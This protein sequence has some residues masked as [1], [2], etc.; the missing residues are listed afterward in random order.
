M[1]T[2]VTNCLCLAAINFAALWLGEAWL[3]WSSTRHPAGA[4][5]PLHLAVSFA[6][7]LVWDRFS[8]TFLRMPGLAIHREKTLPAAALTAVFGVVYYA[9]AVALGTRLSPGRMILVVGWQ[10][11][12]TWLSLLVCRQYEAWPATRRQKAVLAR[13]LALTGGLLSCALLIGVV[14]TMSFLLLK[15]KPPGPVTAFEGDY[16]TP[17]AF[18]RHDDDLGTALEPN[19]NVHCRRLIDGRQ[20]WDVHYGTDEYGRRRTTMKPGSIPEHTAVFFGCSYMFGEGAEDSETIP[21]QFC[22]L[23]PEYRAVNYGVPGYGTQQMLALLESGILPSQT[24]G[25]VRLGVYLYL[26]EIHEARVVGDMDVVNGFAADF[27]YYYMDQNGSPVRAGSFV[28]GRPWSTLLYSVLGKSNTVSL[29]G[30][31]FPRR[32]SRHFQLTAATI[33][34]AR[35]L[36]QKQF[37]GSK[38]LVVRYPLPSHSSTVEICRSSNV[39]IIEL[40]AEFD[41]GADVNVHRGDGHPTP[42]ANRFVAE[43]IA[44]AVE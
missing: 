15:S 2:L 20:I 32:S 23:R 12:A 21:S 14:E 5:L 9:T 1:K 41:P 24:G 34:R 33:C 42:T 29:L 22:E 36:F 27:P 13:V 17:G 30:L 26:P 28:S 25:S 43:R 11:S 10:V 37:P 7:T 31:N 18:Y 3:E 44:E 39:S 4:L 19:R 35:D 6:G 38:L 8:K 40:P 16:L